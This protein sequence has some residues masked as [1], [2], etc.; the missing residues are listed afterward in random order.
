VRRAM[1]GNGRYVIYVLYVPSTFRAR[2]HQFRQ[3]VSHEVER[4]RGAQPSEHRGRQVADVA[5]LEV[6]GVAG[7]GVNECL[8]TR[9]RAEG[10]GRL[11]SR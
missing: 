7:R 1:S 11:M 8:I 6:S 2:V 9:A 5:V 10:P 4:W 3:R